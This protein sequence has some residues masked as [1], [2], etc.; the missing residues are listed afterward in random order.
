MNAQSRMSKVLGLLIA[1]FVGAVVAFS[2]IDVRSKAQDNNRRRMVTLG[3]GAVGI[4]PGEFARLSASNFG[5]RVMQVH[6]AVI[7]A[8]ANTLMTVTQPRSVDP[9]HTTAFDFRPQGLRQ[10]IIAIVGA[11]GTRPDRCPS[12]NAL[13][14]TVQVIDSQS[15]RDGTFVGGSDF[16]TV[17]TP[18]AAVLSDAPGG[19]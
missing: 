1:V 15:H 6:F 19:R 11:D 14:P 8:T 12:D 18:P 3:S 5:S 17:Q 2:V 16:F 10:E 13:V 9:G 4:G 7:D